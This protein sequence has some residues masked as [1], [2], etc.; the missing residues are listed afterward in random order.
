MYD[1]VFLSYNEPHA[2]QH[3]EL[4]KNRFPRAVHVAG[5][6][7]IPQAHRAA[8]GRCQ[9]SYFWVID[10]DNIVNDEYDLTFTFPR[11]NERKDHVAVWKARNNINGLEY[12]YGG[13]KLLP[14][15]AVLNMPDSVVDF[16]TSISDLFHVMDEVAST[17]I[18]NST[19]FEAWRSGFRECVK[20]SSGIITGGHSEESIRRLVRWTTMTLISLEVPNSEYC[21]QGALLGS[22]YGTIN[23]GDPAA[24]ALINDWEW[25]HARFNSD[26]R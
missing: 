24:L 23:Q 12:G 15:R 22:D 9:T 20:L 7:G 16:T 14:R 2:Q 4:V 17:T 3:W 10:A 5:V 25:L 19:P 6:K 11:S 18:I 13:I 8:A 1:I 21:I 26:T